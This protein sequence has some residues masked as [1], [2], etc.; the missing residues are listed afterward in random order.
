[1]PSALHAGPGHSFRKY[2][3]AGIYGMLVTLRF[4]QLLLDDEC[5]GWS[6]WVLGGTQ[7][8]SPSES[9]SATHFTPSLASPIHLLPIPSFPHHFSPRL[10]PGLVA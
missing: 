8:S 3:I 10:L 6:I 7:D 4:T 5:V 9:P 2:W 1:M